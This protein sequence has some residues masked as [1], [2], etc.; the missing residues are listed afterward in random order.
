MM[1]WRISAFSGGRKRPGT[2]R[3][4]GGFSP[5]TF[6]ASDGQKQRFVVHLFYQLMTKRRMFV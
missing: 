2:Q 4:P 3:V 6:A 5:Q 1:M